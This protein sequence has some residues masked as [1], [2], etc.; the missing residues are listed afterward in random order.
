[1]DGWTARHSMRLAFSIITACIMS[2]LSSGYAHF[3]CVSTHVSH[4]SSVREFN[5]L[6][7][8]TT[9]VKTVRT[10]CS[11]HFGARGG[12]HR[13]VCAAAVR[14]FRVRAEC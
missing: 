5:S 14:T 3:N 9:V 2:P 4:K 6:A 11:E 10:N 1:M 12:P 7:S 13:L 8:E